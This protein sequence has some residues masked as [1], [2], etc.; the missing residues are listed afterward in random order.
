MVVN[1]A[2]RLCAEASDTQIFIDSKVF[3]SIAALAA[4]E[5]VGELVL[6]GFSRPVRAYNLL[7]AR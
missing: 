6:K 4:A 3:A 5:P 1:L 7:A 2:A